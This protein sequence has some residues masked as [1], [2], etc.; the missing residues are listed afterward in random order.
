M[1]SWVFTEA[2]LLALRTDVMLVIATVGVLFAHAAN[3][4]LQQHSLKPQL[5]WREALVVGA[6]GD[7]NEVKSGITFIHQSTRPQFPA[8]LFNAALLGLFGA[9]AITLSGH[10][11]SPALALIPAALA[12][13]FVA[14][15]AIKI[16]RTSAIRSKASNRALRLI[17]SSF[18]AE[19]SSAL[20]L[21]ITIAVVLHTAGLSFIS[22]IEVAAITMAVRFAVRITPWPAGLGVADAVLLIPLTWI[23]VPLYVGLAS[24]LIWRT[25]T[26]VALVIAMVIAR[27][28]QVQSYDADPTPSVTDR[29]RIVHRT[30][31]ATVGLLPRALRESIRARV[32][33]SLFTFTD[34][35]W[36]YH[37]LP[38]EN[39]KQ[40]YMLSAIRPDVTTVMEMGCADGHNLVSLARLR[41]D[42]TIFGVDISMKA[43]DLA[44]RQTREFDNVHVLAANEYAALSTQ[45]DCVILSEVLYYLGS[46]RAMQATFTPLMT[47]MDPSCHVI[48]LHGS[49]DAVE[50]H[51]RAAN[52]LGL[53]ILQTHTVDDPQRP[54]VR[55]IARTGIRSAPCPQTAS[56]DPGRRRLP[57][58]LARC[59]AW[60]R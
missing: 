26:L 57:W 56:N 35:P 32:F 14:H 1:S 9:I 51:T 54:F 46:E 16:V 23:G 36:G 58:L 6:H 34:D 15:T 42:I 24:V 2:A 41:P 20:A 10:P 40:D 55:T 22:L 27:N 19:I 18:C 39:R 47:L 29:G 3:A 43:V 28:T 49:A 17:V 5:R 12:A 13:F 60:R 8:A 45:L 11:P 7:V 21:I 59:G 33:D 4:T 25:G 48:M 37:V 50:L 38:Y 30:L 44:R 31:F 53:V 52:A